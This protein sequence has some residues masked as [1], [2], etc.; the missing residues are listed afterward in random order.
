[1]PSCSRRKGGSLVNASAS[2]RRPSARRAVAALPALLLM[3]AG[4]APIETA[5]A[6]DA[7]P[8]VVVDETLGVV[9]IAPDSDIALRIVLDGDED[10]ERLGAVLEAAFRAAVEDFGVVQQSFRVDLDAV[11]ATTCDAEDGIR[12]AAVVLEAADVVGVLGPQCT[13]TLLGLQGPL[14]DEGLVVIAPRPTTVEFTVEP[15]GSVGGARVDGTWRTSPSLLSEGRAAAS[16]AAEG[17]ELLRAAVLHDGNTESM[18]VATAFQQRFESLGG[19]VV[20]TREIIGDALTEDAEGAS[21]QRD[22]LLDAV[23]ASDPDVAFLA[24][25]PEPLLDL[26]AGWSD[27]S[28]LAAVT[29]IATNRAGTPAFLAE[30]GSIGHLL[31]VPAIDPGE[32]VSTVT[33]MSAS[34]TLERVESSAAVV[35]PQGWWA[36]AYDAAT[37][38]L[39]AIDDTSLVDSDGALVISRA[40]LRTTIA[41]TAFGGLSGRLACTPTGDCAEGRVLILAHEDPSLTRVAALPVIAELAG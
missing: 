31:T 15:D 35:D 4:C 34:Q 16:H 3:I 14:S 2:G 28:S 20:I 6:P 12:A 19:T 29:R 26:S 37:L 33:G 11:I 24:L 23:A 18:S 21:P 40:E 25:A 8:P 13:A 9:R 38:L 17:L 5:E 41:R 7:A 27:R 32:R 22:E 36:M 39:K 10:P 1:M 30:E